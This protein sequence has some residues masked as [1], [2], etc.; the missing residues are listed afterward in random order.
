KLGAFEIPSGGVSVN[1]IIY[2]VCTTDH[3]EKKGMGRSVM[4][5]SNDDGR[6]FKL[7]YDLSRDK[8]I[9]VSFVQAGGWIYIYG[10]G[11][12]RKSSVCLA[13]AKIT[14][15]GDRSKLQY[16]A[17]TDQDAKPR[18]LSTEADAVPLFQ[19]DVVGEL[20]VVY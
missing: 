14:D 19:H 1:G 15:L 3:T 12:Y 9:N 6:S 8:F 7:L 11:E 13:R 20:S 16:F 18:W 10:S 5:G 4:A 2:V 17:G